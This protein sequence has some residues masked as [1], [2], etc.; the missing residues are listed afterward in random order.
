MARRKPETIK[1]S[2]ADIDT[3]HAE[4]LGRIA[5]GKGINASCLDKDMM[6]LFAGRPVGDPRS[7]PELDAWNRGWH[8]ANVASAS[9]SMAGGP[10]AEGEEEESAMGMM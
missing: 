4:S 5:F 2:A 7:I 3:S 8:K 9:E 6:A 10:Q 1:N